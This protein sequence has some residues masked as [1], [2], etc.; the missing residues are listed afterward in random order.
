[1]IVVPILCWKKK[2]IL[3]PPDTKTRLR[4]LAVACSSGLMLMCVFEGINR[5]PFGDYSAIAFSSPVFCMLLSIFLLKDY[6]GLYRGLLGILLTVG[7]V[8]ISRPSSLFSDTSLPDIAATNITN[9]IFINN[10]TTDTT[11]NNLMKKE[12]DVVGIVLALTGAILSAWITIL[13]R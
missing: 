5:L 12:T 1:M 2:N 7:V 3:G 10:I 11:E 13:V 6:F 8:I 4:V 9:N